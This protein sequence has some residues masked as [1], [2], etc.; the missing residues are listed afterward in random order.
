VDDEA[1]EIIRAALGHDDEDDTRVHV[2]P[3]LDGGRGGGMEE[4]RSEGDCEGLRF[5][6]MT[7]DGVIY[8]TEERMAAS[9]RGGAFAKR[10]PASRVVGEGLRGRVVDHLEKLQ[11]WDEEIKKE[12][13]LGRYDVECVLN[14]SYNGV[15]RELNALISKHPEI[16]GIFTI[17]WTGLFW[18]DY[19]LPPLE[20]CPCGEGD[21]CVKTARKM[22]RVSQLD[23]VLRLE[24]LPLL[25][26]CYSRLTQAHKEAFHSRY[27]I[28]LEDFL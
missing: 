22:G 8:S 10:F 17:G 7:K 9:N 27:G 16:A 18:D 3:E 21:S 24:G 19:E 25:A 15:M 6:V 28:N 12:R 20:E 13:D 11:F 14:R 26:H 1:F 4:G 5:Q 23:A 2:D